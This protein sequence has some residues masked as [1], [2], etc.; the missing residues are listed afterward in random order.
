MGVLG[1]G[2]EKE[3]QFH[4]PFLLITSTR[5][6]QIRPWLQS[7]PRAY[8]LGS[9]QNPSSFPL[10]PSL[11]SLTLSIAVD[12]FSLSVNVY[13]LS[14]FGYFQKLGVRKIYELASPTVLSLL[15]TALG[16]QRAGKNGV[17]RWIKETVVQK[18]TRKGGKRGY[19]AL[20]LWRAG[21]RLGLT[22]KEFVEEEP[23][24][25]S[26]SGTDTKVWGVRNQGI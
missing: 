6:F 17:G 14:F 2:Y 22:G 11:Q 5:R 15:K 16:L 8:F 24:E 12:I 1:R 3:G 10:L 13:I 20:L 26:L 21:A 19:R 25:W 23:S 18:D 9:K 7:M 4:L